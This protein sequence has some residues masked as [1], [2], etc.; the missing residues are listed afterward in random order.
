MK[1]LYFTAGPVP[2][3]NEK[4]DIAAL[5]AFAVA[6]FEVGV[7]NALQVGASGAQV[8]DADY[9]AVVSGG[10]IPEPYDDDETYPVFDPAAPPASAL[11]ATVG[12]VADG[13]VFDVTGGT[14]EVTVTDGVVTMEFTA[15]P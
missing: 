1:I 11:P 3:S 12:L 10:T 4:A 8:E 2:T 6:P 5:N 15:D 13:Q 7:R 9:V 14:V